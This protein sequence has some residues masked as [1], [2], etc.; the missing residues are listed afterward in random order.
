MDRDEQ[1]R[2]RAHRIWEEEG[3]PDGRH[4]DHWERASRE[5]DLGSPA[6]QEQ[7]GMAVD[8]GP[9]QPAGLDSS[10]DGPGSGKRGTA[11]DRPGGAPGGV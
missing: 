9:A 10:T 5:L 4:D 6:G 2:I 11:T 8:R 1:I 3:R 7:E